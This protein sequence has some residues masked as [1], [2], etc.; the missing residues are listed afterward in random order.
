M[1]YIKLVADGKTIYESYENVP[2]PDKILDEFIKA[3][4]RSAIYS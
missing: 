4:V 2:I 3:Q 1:P